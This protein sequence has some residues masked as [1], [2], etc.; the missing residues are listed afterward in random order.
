MDPSALPSFL[1][2]TGVYLHDLLSV[3]YSIELGFHIQAAAGDGTAI[4]A[5]QRVLSVP[6]GALFR[7]FLVVMQC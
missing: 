4:K 7:K 6:I 1:S 5:G 2:S 3:Q